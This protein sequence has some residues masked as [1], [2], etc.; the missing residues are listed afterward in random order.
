MN[1]TADR[2]TPFDLVIAGAG[3]S[4]LALAGAA[5][6]AG[7]RVAVVDPRIGS[8]WSPTWCAF[9]RD[10]PAWVPVARRWAIARVELPGRS[11]AIAREYAQVDGDGLQRVLLERAAGIEP[12]E[13]RAVARVE[14][15]LQT[16]RGVV[17]GRRVVDCTGG[18]GALEPGS[19]SAYQTAFG[20]EVDTEGHPWDPSEALWMDLRDLA[21][22]PS[23][24]YAL[25][26]DER[27]VFVEE[28]A[29]AAR[30]EV[31]LALL[32]A[33]LQARFD[34]H[35][36]RVRGV[37]RVERCRIP[38]DVAVPRDL[39]F[40]SAGGMVHPATGYLLARV[41][42]HADAV[43]A[44][45]LAGRGEQ[46]LRAARGGRARDL[47]LLGL[48]VLTASDGPA[49]TAFFD[50]FFDAPEAARDA[51]LSPTPGAGS[52]ALA[53]ARVF[54]AAPN[55]VRRRLLAPLFGARRLQEV[56]CP[57]P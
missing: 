11:L 50:A 1:S 21:P 46:A 53:M 20:L 14:G 7:A 10:L 6:R 29:L 4:G 32:E 54:L 23:F 35:G 17:A 3:P 57:S 16:D 19:P 8:A 45:V 5:L 36:V 13:A 30:P 15:G 41:L 18:A 27:A 38:L 24:L 2:T 52:T 44:G 26:I 33:R 22:T 43:A 48:D 40:G 56:E 31:P 55:P 9:S 39:A 34:R 12:V 25:P 47:H 37:R 28:T 51:F 49:L 42:A